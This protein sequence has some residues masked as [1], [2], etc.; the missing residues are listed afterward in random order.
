MAGLRESQ[1]AERRI[2]M[3]D[4][5]RRHFLESGFEAA[6]IEAIAE[7]AGVSAV[8][9]YN[10]YGT[11]RGLLLALV[12]QSDTFLIGKI[13][14]F[15]ADP[16]NDPLEAFAGISVVIRDHNLGYLKR[17]IWRHVI[18]TSV[19]EGSSDFGRGYAALDQKLGA[20]FGCLLDI[21][22]RCGTLDSAIDCTAAGETLFKLQNARF[23]ELMADDALT[24]ADMDHRVR[25]D[26]AFVLGHHMAGRKS[27]SA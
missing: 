9:V 3:L 13:D 1:K 4:A 14:A 10:Y 12:G 23:I 2:R 18:A 26:I 7:S 6:T 22:V 19:I 15:M 16:P 20:L 21:L 11:K 8:T 5:A 24:P 25:G 17:P 27:M